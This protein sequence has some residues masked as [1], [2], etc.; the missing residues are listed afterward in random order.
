MEGFDHILE[1]DE[2]AESDFVPNTIEDF[3]DTK[4]VRENSLIRFDTL[5]G[6]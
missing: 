6:D 1:H 4:K 2:V 3:H 5:K